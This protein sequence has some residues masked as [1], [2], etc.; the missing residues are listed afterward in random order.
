MNIK[1]INKIYFSKSLPTKVL[2]VFILG[3]GLK[4]FFSCTPPSPIEMHYNSINI[5]G[6]DNSDRFIDKYTSVDT[7][8]SGAVALKLS[9]FDSTYN[10]YA[11]NF[12]KVFKSLSFTPAMALT[13]DES[14]I[15]VNKVEQLRIITLFDIDENV[16]AGDDISNLIVYDAGSDFE[17]YQ[18][19]NY[20]IATLNRTQATAGSSIV[21]VLRTSIENTK[22]Q[23]GV[24]ITLDN[25]YDLSF[26]TD[27]FTIIT[28]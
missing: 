15:P 11:F 24:K 13:I 21:M 28:Q 18:N 20:A 14:F 17:L 6:I 7:M 23:F 26:I 3:F 2:I 22:A 19:L 8:Y 10:Y 27:M 25:G 16:K 9:L 12:Y 4:L 5:I 1:K